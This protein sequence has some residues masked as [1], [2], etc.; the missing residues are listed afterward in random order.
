MSHGLMQF[1]GCT[2]VGTRNL[3]KTVHQISCG[4]KWRLKVAWRSHMHRHFNQDVIF[5]YA[6][7]VFIPVM[8]RQ[9]SGN[10]SSF[11]RWELSKA[12]TNLVFNIMSL[13]LAYS[14]SIKMTPIPQSWTCSFVRW[15]VLPICRLLL[16]VWA[17]G[18]HS[19]S[20]SLPGRKGF[21]CPSMS[22]SQRWLAPISHN[23]WGLGNLKVN[24][25][26]LSFRSVSS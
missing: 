1:L 5:G 13:F 2:K 15:K 25:L 11:L 19:S 24:C 14:G 9:Y 22:S 4:V 21:L 3:W 23:L 10:A 8:S 20:C 12:I 17:L 6:G 16:I 26:T 7:F 18:V